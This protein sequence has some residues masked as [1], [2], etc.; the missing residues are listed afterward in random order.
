M[1]ALAA[2]SI[3]AIDPGRAAGQASFDWQ[4]FKGRHVEVFLQKGPR[5]DLLQQYQKEFETLTGISVGS[6]QIPEQQQ[7]QK[8]MIEFTPRR[9]LEARMVRR[10]WHR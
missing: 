9:E 3:L 2:P 5:A 6:E 8:L 7:R 4:R 10:R 1:S